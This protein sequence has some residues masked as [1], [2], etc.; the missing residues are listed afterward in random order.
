MNKKNNQIYEEDYSIDLIELISK[1]RK[2][3]IFIIKSTLIFTLIGI[4]YSL[5]LENN[6]KASSVFYPHY[7]NNEINT[8]QGLRSIAGLAG[9]NLGN[10]STNNIPTALYPNIISS[11]DFKINIL[12]SKINLNDTEITYR[13]YLLNKKKNQL[14]LKK[15]ILYPINLLSKL[16]N[17]TNT[18]KSLETNNIIQLSEEEYKLHENLSNLIFLELKEKQGFIQLSVKDNN[19]FIASQ[20]AKTANDILQQKI[21]NFKIK[22]IND[23]YKFIKTQLEVAKSKFLDIYLSF[24]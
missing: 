23:T 4:I 7:Q 21:I 10:T 19:P 18:N 17:K 14:N 9:I 3:K 2:S 8:G 22:N 5:S 12:D 16:I 20:I 1:L 11:P 6:F 24:F 13:E 15:I